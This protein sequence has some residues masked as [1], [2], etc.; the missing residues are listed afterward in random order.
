M[1]DCRR[2]SRAG[3]RAGRRAARHRR[4]GPQS[5]TS[6]PARPMRRYS[7]APRAHA[8][9]SSR[10]RI[11]GPR[12]TSP[13]RR[14]CRTTGALPAPLTRRA[15]PRP[16]FRAGWRWARHPDRGRRWR[17]CPPAQ[18]RR[19]AA[20]SRAAPGRPPRQ[21]AVDRRVARPDACR[22]RTAAQRRRHRAWSGGWRPA[23]RAPPGGPHHHPPAG[24][25]SSRPHRS[26]KARRACPPAFRHATMARAAG[27]AP[28]PCP[29]CGC[30]YSRTGSCRSRAGPARNSA[31]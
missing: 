14:P 15:A 25:R 22:C 17:S 28:P 24:G 19:R 9:R 12:R 16:G 7:C 2:G 23:A 31:R 3:I 21:S 18:L 10:H 11:R 29:W 8:E 6:P 30:R 1:A 26:G 13:S 5:R 27:N 20:G 4:C